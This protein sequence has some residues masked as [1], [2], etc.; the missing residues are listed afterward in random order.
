[1][2]QTHSWEPCLGVHSPAVVSGAYL[3]TD[4]QCSYMCTWMSEEPPVRLESTGATCL[5]RLRPRREGPRS[6]GPRVLLKLSICAPQ[7]PSSQPK[8][9]L[10]SQ[11]FPF[12]AWKGW[13]VSQLCVTVMGQPRSWL[14]RR[15]VP[16]GFGLFVLS[17]WRG[18]ASPWEHVV[19][20]GGGI[21]GE[22]CCLS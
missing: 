4:P 13:H 1:M 14:E 20:A 12:L 10:Q 8:H 15:K 6:E 18:N 2:L 9:E 17:L 7:S 21:Q 16:L 11:V 5:R 22:A 3:D 19:R